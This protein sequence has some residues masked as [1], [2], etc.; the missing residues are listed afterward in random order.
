MKNDSVRI[1][2]RFEAATMQFLHRESALSN[3]SVS[4]LVRELVQFF[5]ARGSLPELASGY[6]TSLPPSE[7][8]GSQEALRCLYYLIALAESQ[9]TGPHRD[10]VLAEASQLA[11]VLFARHHSPSSGDAC[12]CFSPGRQVSPRLSPTG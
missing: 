8:G 3:K 1:S 5:E 4:V 9:V 10:R 11:E 7:A 6:P 2:V 12:A